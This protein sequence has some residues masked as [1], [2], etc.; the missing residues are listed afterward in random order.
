MANLTFKH[1]DISNLTADKLSDGDIAF[2]TYGT[3]GYGTIG[4]KNG[5]KLL[6]LLPTPGEDGK[7]LIGKGTSARPEYATL[8]I[9]GGGTGATAF[10]NN[11][12]LY[13]DPNSKTMVSGNHFINSESVAINATAVKPET[14][15]VN[16]NGNITDALILGNKSMSGM[17]TAYHFR[18]TYNWHDSKNPL[19]YL[20]TFTSKDSTQM[21]TI[22]VTGNSYKEK[23]PIYSI[24]QF[25]NYPPSL[26]DPKN[27]GILAKSGRC[28][29]WDTGSIY[30]YNRGANV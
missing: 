18:P 15:Y 6:K 2:A 11:R 9:S 29:G 7:P 14:L 10:T 25:Y 30:V 26:E 12:L 17:G 22:V 23:A 19:G 3:S 20:F 4:V 27:F 1:G 28:F 16:G 5:T 21:I 13:V 8:G 24:Y